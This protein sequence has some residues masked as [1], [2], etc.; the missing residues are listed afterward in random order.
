MSD[1][2]AEAPGPRFWR[3]WRAL[4]HNLLLRRLVQALPVLAFATF[5][6]FGLLKLVPG[7]VAIALAGDNPSDARLA[8][9]RHL[10]GLDRPF[11]VQYGSWLWHAVQGDLAKSLLSG[12]SV[13]V[14]IGQSLP[15]TLL[16]VVMA[17]VISV[18]VGVPLGMLAAARRG[19]WVDGLVMTIASLGVAVPNFW[20][21]MVLIVGFALTLN[22]LPATGAVSF[23]VDPLDAMRHALLPALALAASGVAELSRQLRSSLVDMLSSQQ[24][25]T[26]H[27]KGLSPASILWKHGLRNVGTN[28]LTVI[29]LLANRMLAATVVIEAVFAIPGT[30]SLIVNAVLTRD[31]PVVQGVVFVMVLMVIAINLVADILVG[32]VDPRLAR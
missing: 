20:L 8:E 17:L 26:L 21:A 32:L 27:A 2:A 24:V 12:E 25:R 18:A 16:I 31:Y 7:D 30:G 19:R 13:R 1:A 22:W 3:L 23:G 29:A 4:R 15:H 5:V 14:S 10:Y 11:L 6:V 9:I 28:L